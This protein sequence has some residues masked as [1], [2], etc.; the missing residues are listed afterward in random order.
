[1]MPGTTRPAISMKRG[2]GQSKQQ[3]QRAAA[4]AQQR[5]EP[6]TP[7][8]AQLPILVV[9]VAPRAC[10]SGTIYTSFWPDICA[11]LLGGSSSSAAPL[12]VGLPFEFGFA[13]QTNDAAAGVNTRQPKSL[14]SRFS[15]MSGSFPMLL[16]ERP[17]ITK[18]VPPGKS[19]SVSAGSAGCNTP[20]I[21]N[22]H[23]TGQCQFNPMF[24]AV[25]LIDRIPCGNGGT[26]H[27]LRFGLPDSS[28]AM[29]LPTCACIL[30]S[31]D[32][33]D[34]TK[35]GETTKVIRPYTPIST[36]DQVGSFDLLI[37]DYGENG[38]LSKY[39]CEELK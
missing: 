37:K 7:T 19:D 15:L 4:A 33:P 25:P 1:M 28:R 32:L 14:V 13:D 38:W 23:S 16:A 8:A 39:M 21:A 5:P 30:A 18:L 6:A 2:V 10:P 27:I 20:N 29:D 17:P 35:N 26:S 22:S 3:Q 36:N 24:Q 12:S 34:D 9:A 11:G 31:A